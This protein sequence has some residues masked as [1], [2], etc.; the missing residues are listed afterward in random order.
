[1]MKYGKGGVADWATLCGALNGAAA[2]IYLVS[3]KPEPVV[4]ELFGWYQQE[5][6]PVHQPKESKLE[7]VSSFSRSTLCHASV[8]QWCKASKFK[9]FSEER[10]E[11]CARLTADVTKKSVALLNQEL[12]GTFKPIFPIPESEKQCR[13]CYD[14]GGTLENTRGKID[15]SPCH[16]NLGTAH[17][18]I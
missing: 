14:K 9:A 7:I 17:K 3:S 6:L 15:C 11:R 8:S 13:T 10:E 12:A 1:M 2:A 4:D 18:K 16:F 5:K